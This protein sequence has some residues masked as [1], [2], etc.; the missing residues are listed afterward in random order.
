MIPA[1][2]RASIFYRS[3]RVVLSAALG[4]LSV[5]VRALEPVARR[6]EVLR[7]PTIDVTDIRFARFY[8]VEGPSKSNAGPF[9]QDNQ[10]FVWFGTP[11][12]LNRF[13]GYTFKVFVHATA[14]PKSINLNSTSKMY[15]TL[16][17]SEVTCRWL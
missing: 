4:A 2:V 14:N 10:G 11:Y 13:D 17:P 7:V 12:D 8:T 16:G 15:T 6:P 1:S 5:N 9:A 3:C